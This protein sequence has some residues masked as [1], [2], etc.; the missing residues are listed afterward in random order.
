MPPM[1]HPPGNVTYSELMELV[2]QNLRKS[3]KRKVV[4]ALVVEAKGEHVL[5]MLTIPISPASLEVFCVRLATRHFARYGITRKS[6][7]DWLNILRIHRQL[8]ASIE[9]R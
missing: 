1:F 7:E 6:V 8:R 5:C 4:D 3:C 2:F 9:N